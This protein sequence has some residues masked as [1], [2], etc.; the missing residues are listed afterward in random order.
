MNSTATMAKLSNKFWLVMRSFE[1]HSAYWLKTSSFMPLRKPSLGDLWFWKGVS[2]KR[3]EDL[4]SL[5]WLHGWDD[6][7]TYTHVKRKVCETMTPW[8]SLCTHHSRSRMVQKENILVPTVAKRMNVLAKDV[9]TT[10]HSNWKTCFGFVGASPSLT[11]HISRHARAWGSR[12][13][14][15]RARKTDKKDEHMPN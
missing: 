14:V 6:M 7:R 1:A 2:E 11:L 15:W 5:W 13:K 3:N 9:I 8:S 10:L 12:R 4:K